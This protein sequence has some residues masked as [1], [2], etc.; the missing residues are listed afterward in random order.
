MTKSVQLRNAIPETLYNRLT[1]E[2]KRDGVTTTH[3]LVELLRKH[4]RVDQ[5]EISAFNAEQERINTEREEAEFR[6]KVAEAKERNRLREAAAPVDELD[7]LLA[8]MPEPEDTRFPT[9]DEMLKRRQA[10]L[11]ARE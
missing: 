1:I 4:L 11:D 6:R 3:V 5:R 2:A 7:A 8:E 9:E 10:V